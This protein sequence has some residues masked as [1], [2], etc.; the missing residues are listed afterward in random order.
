MRPLN[1]DREEMIP[2]P[3]IAA[4]Q[5]PENASDEAGILA[6]QDETLQALPTDDSADIGSLGTK[7][8]F[9]VESRDFQFARG[10][11]DVKEQM[12]RTT[13]EADAT[14]HRPRDPNVTPFSDDG[15]VD[16]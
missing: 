14:L 13:A 16:R 3:P 15:R 10:E 11:I 9:G 1:Q 8:D 5:S 4:G 7:E 6:D 2:E 12:D